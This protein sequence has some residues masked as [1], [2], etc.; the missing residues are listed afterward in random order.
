MNQV[1]TVS[2]VY[3]VHMIALSLF[4]RCGVYFCFAGSELVK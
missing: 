2:K 3:K 1:T 4:A